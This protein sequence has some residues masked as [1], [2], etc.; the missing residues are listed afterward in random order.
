MDDA[1]E[2]ARAGLPERH[3]GR[4]RLPGEGQ[5]KGPG[6]ALDLA[7]RGRAFSPPSW[8][9]PPSSGFPLQELPLRAGVAAALR[10]RTPRHRVRIKWP[11]DLMAG[12][13]EKLAGL[14]CEAHGGRCSDRARRELPQSSFP[15]E[16]AGTACSLLQAQR[17]GRAA[18]SL[19]SASS[20]RLKDVR[21]TRPGGRSFS[22]APTG[23]ADWLTVDL[24][25]IRTDGGRD[26]G[27][28]GRAGPAGPARSG[29]ASRE[30]AQGEISDSR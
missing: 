9:H 19:L 14:L 26:P 6:P 8:S 27:G 12:R 10:E 5:G 21:P 22:A 23:G 17:Q 15:P 11:N 20:P 1:L 30:D 13:A 16:L 29:T 4:G 18:S 28:C 2:L 25:G 24:F 3:R 7:R